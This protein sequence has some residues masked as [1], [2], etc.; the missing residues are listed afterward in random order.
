MRHAETNDPELP[1]GVAD[2]NHHRGGNSSSRV[3]VQEKISGMVR[4]NPS[5]GLKGAERFSFEGLEISAA[6]REYAMRVA[7]AT[8]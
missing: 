1:D 4:V 7:N 6:D 3:S 8:H 2:S 5:E